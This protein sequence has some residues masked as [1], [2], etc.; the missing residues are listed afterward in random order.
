MLLPAAGLWLLWLLRLLLCAEW[1]AAWILLRRRRWSIPPY[2][3][4]AMDPYSARFCTQQQ[5]TVNSS[6]TTMQWPFD[7][8]YAARILFPIL[9][10]HSR[11]TNTATKKKTFFFCSFF[12]NIFQFW[13]WPKLE[14]LWTRF[15][16]FFETEFK[17]LR[18]LKLGKNL[19]QTGTSTTKPKK[20]INKNK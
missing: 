14:S 3:R 9:I 13:T 17:S 8:V 11:E 18:A 4:W 16:I 10:G 6:V 15:R 5:P 1:I 19:K 2:R 7:P 20:L 12:N